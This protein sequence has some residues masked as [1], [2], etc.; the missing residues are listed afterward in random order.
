MFKKLFYLFM[1]FVLVNVTLLSGVTLPAKAETDP[2]L[3]KSR[4]ELIEKAID[5]SKEY[6]DSSVSE[7]KLLKSKIKQGAVKVHNGNL[8]FDQSFAKENDKH[9]IVYIPSKDND[10][11]KELNY[12]MF[13][14]VLDKK[15]NIV[16]YI[17]MII[18]GNDV[19]YTSNISVYSNGKLV[20][21]EK[22]Q[23][24]KEDFMKNSSDK[25][26]SLFGEKKA[27]AASFWSKFSK[28]LDRMGV[29][30]WV[31]TSISVICSGVCVVTLGT[32][33][34]TCVVGAGLVTEG[35]MVK[36]VHEGIRGK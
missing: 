8:D 32:A 24:T 16:N 27:N 3:D 19:D 23:L 7:I 35:V 30:S 14:I 20:K 6:D 25:S 11:D 1:G 31:I 17:E 9:K 12:T 28:C 33:C 18:N 29:A 2:K 13:S 34:I 36:C 4:E 22:L 15:G 5:F 21:D 26:V 10:L